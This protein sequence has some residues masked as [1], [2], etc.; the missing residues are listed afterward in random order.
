MNIITLT[1][2]PA[3]D[4][5][6]KIDQLMPEQKLNCTDIEYQAGGGGINIS[7]VLHTLEVQNKCVF[8]AGGDTGLSLKLLLNEED[9]AVIPVETEAWTRENLAVVDEKTEQQYRFGMPGTR[10]TAEEIEHIKTIISTQV[11]DNSIFIMSGSLSEHMPTD[12]YVQ[13]MH[14]LADKQVKIIVDTSGKALEVTLSEPVF[15]MKPNQ[16]EL[17]QLAGKSFLSKDE[18]EHFAMELVNTGR[19]QYVVVSLGARGAFLASTEGIF[20]RN[21]PSVKVKSTIGAGDSMVAGLVYG[22]QHGLSSEDILKWGVICGVATTMTGGTN[23]AS[24]ENINR[25]KALM[26]N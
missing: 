18:Q 3:L 24:K 23:L 9:I 11:T 2:N 16:K 6:A 8:T 13:L 15:L 25:V 5:S 12:L 20:Y 26:E 17:A 21:T 4:K 14:L 19:A 10:L 7:R 1:V 22:I